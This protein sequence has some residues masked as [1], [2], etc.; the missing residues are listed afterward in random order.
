MTSTVS[1]NG[2]SIGTGSNKGEGLFPQ[3]VTLATGTTAFV[4]NARIT[5]GADNYANKSLRVMYTTS[6]YSIT[7]AQAVAQ[8]KR[9]ARFL[10]VE[11][12]PNGSGVV[13]KDSSFEPVTGAFLYFWCN[14]PILATAATL[15]VTATELP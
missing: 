10:D 11:F 9:T 13:I 12:D 7:A 3:K 14:I 1:I 5:N 4:L 8:L 2:Q 15:D 6:P